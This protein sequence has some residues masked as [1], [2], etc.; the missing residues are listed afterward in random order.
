MSNEQI[1][2]RRFFKKSAA[3]ALATAGLAAAGLA[4]HESQPPVK[5]S[6]LIETF[7][8]RLQDAGPTLALAHGRNRDELLRRCLDELGGIGRFIKDGDNVLLK[9]NAGFASPAYIGA[10]THPDLLKAMIVICRQ[11]GA[12]RVVV[13]DNP[14][15]NP[16]LCFHSN[17]LAEVCQQQGAEL[18]I[19]QAGDFSPL[20]LAGGRLLRNWPFLLKPLQG[21]NKLIGM[22]PVKN[23]VRAQAT[24]GLKNF[25]GLLGGGRGI[26]H[27]DIHQIVLELAQLVRPTLSVLDG[28]Q[29]MLRNGPTGGSLEDLSDSETM[30]AG[31]DAVAVDAVGAGLLHLR[32]SQIGYLNLCRQAGLGSWENA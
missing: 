31:T 8:Y 1:S 32:P 10:T 7:D 21:I 22:A 27:Q 24:M 15:S 12:K 3:L 25:Y 29:A 14:I 4:F 18:I 6:A 13:S 2:R 30:I 16:A 28:V 20:T 11:A 5:N 23:H 19:P 9:V 17:G 26:F